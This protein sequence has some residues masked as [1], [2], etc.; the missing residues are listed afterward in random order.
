MSAPRPRWRLRVQVPASPRIAAGGDAVLVPGF[1]RA[2]RDVLAC[3]AL[4]DGA[5]RWEVALDDF[6]LASALAGVELAADPDGDAV[7]LAQDATVA[8][9]A[10][11]TGAKRWAVRVPADPPFESFTLAGPPVIAGRRLLLRSRRSRLVALER[12]DGALAWAADGPPAADVLVVGDVAIS[13][14]MGPGEVRAHDRATG[15][16]RWT[17]SGVEPIALVAGSGLD[18]D[19]TYLV[20]DGRG[21]VA[22]DAST[23]DP[24][25]QT[26][27]SGAARAAQVGS[28]VIL[29]DDGSVR[30]LDAASGAARW[31]LP[32]RGP[33][34]VAPLDGATVVVVRGA[35]TSVLDAATGKGRD[36]GGLRVEA[37]D[38]VLDAR[39]GAV[40]LT[41]DGG[42]AHL[43]ALEAS[44][45]LR[46]QVIGEATARPGAPA[47]HGVL[48][49]IAFAG[50]AVTIDTAH[51]LCRFDA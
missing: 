18:D 50:G 4:A 5:S 11:A 26:P 35:A 51:E 7:Y 2:R 41:A 46:V 10:I 49:A 47:P 28:V 20:T 27:V 39:G 40:A 17:R 15:A 43:L 32:G 33:A 6:I 8:C 3:H 30:G 37:H 13:R 44:G 12:R 25:W 1:G 34:L 36:H 31:V 45:G 24:R 22:L 23:G 21:V 19:R 16:A 38:R 48:Q 42:L 14:S 29:A 9:F